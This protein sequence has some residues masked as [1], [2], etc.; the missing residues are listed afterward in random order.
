MGPLADNREDTLIGSALFTKTQQRVLGLLFGAPDASF[1][2][3]EIVRQA[4][5]GRGTVRRELERLTGAGLLRVS[6]EGNQRYYQANAESPIYSELIAIVRKSFGMVEVIRE[7][8]LSVDKNITFSFIYGSVSKGQDVA[9]SDIDL[10]VLSDSIVYADLMD[11]LM[12]A[13]DTLGR[14]INPS[15]YSKDELIN[16]TKQKSAFITRIFEQ[17]KLWV[18]GSEDDNRTFRKSGKN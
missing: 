2:T 16:K 4:S 1:Y 18:I 6:R 8:L 12:R 15:V 10:F 11:V 5:M 9:S 14:Q 7:A 3:N 17:P 13:G